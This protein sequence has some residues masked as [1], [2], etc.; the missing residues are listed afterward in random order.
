M[1][2][3]ILTGPYPPP[4]VCVWRCSKHDSFCDRPRWKSFRL[5][6][7]YRSTLYSSLVTRV[8]PSYNKSPEVASKDINK[9]TT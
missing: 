5:T 7:I 6:A 4:A 2:I 8:V 9:I 1:P 3:Y